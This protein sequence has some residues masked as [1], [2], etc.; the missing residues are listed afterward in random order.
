LP[1]TVPVKAEGIMNYHVTTVPTSYSEDRWVRAVEVQPTAR[2]VVHHVLVFARPAGQRGD[3]AANGFL[4]AYV[5]GNTHLIYPEGYAKRL[6][7]GSNLV[8]Q[9]HYTPNGKATTDRTRLGVAFASEAPRHEIH[10][11]GIANTRFQIPAGADNHQI[12]ATLA[13][14]FNARVLALFPHAHLRGKAAKYE[15]TTPEGKVET[16]LDVPHYDFNWQLQYRFTE[17]YLTPRGSTLT[18]TA[19]YDNS[20]KNPANPDPTTEVK[21]G[22]QTFEEMHLGFLEYVVDGSGFGRIGVLAGGLLGQ[23]FPTDV[24]FPKEGLIIPDQFRAGFK[25]FDTNGDG[26]LDQKEFDALPRRV[27]GAI[28]EFVR[29]NMQ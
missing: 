12:K 23:R 7:K 16:L 1:E 9:I 8:F 19:W 3:G 20:S 18:Y 10:S 2:E 13:V 27:Q 25:R 24:K 26:K 28:L 22:E 17:P 4:A 21:W 5:P 15:L 11:V 6:P 29:Q 14:P